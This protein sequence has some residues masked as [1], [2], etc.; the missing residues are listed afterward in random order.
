VAGLDPV[1]ILPLPEWLEAEE[2]TAPR[3]KTDDKSWLSWVIGLAR[4]N[5]EEKTGGPFA[6]AV[7]DLR[8]G[9]LIAAGVNRVEA[10]RCSAAHAEVAALIRAQQ[11]LHTHDLS[12]A[13]G[14]KPLTLFSSAQPCIMCFGALLWSGARRLVYGA[15]KR[16]VERTLGFDEGPLPRLWRLEL[17]RRGLGVRGALLSV[18]ATQVLRFYRDRQ[19]LIYNPSRQDG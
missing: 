13:E 1:L 7:V 2:R 19:G 3:K 11:R 8:S 15:S 14:K 16:D 9:E 6:A 12:Q 18:E 17:R 4:R 5:V 10:L